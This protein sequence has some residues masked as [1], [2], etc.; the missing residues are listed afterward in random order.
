MPSA[1]PVS[2]MAPPRTDLHTLPTWTEDGDLWVVIET[3]KGTPNKLAFDP[4]LGAFRLTKVLPAGM[5]FPF[6]F[7]FIPGTIGEDGD[8]LD[9]LV[10]LDA[11]LWP[12][13]VVA[14]RLLGAFEA[15]QRED[16][17]WVRN[18][19]LVA[20][21]RKTPTNDGLKGIEDLDPVLLDEIEAFFVDYNRVEGRRF[22][23]LGRIG[24]KHARQMVEGAART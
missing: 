1:D 11:P 18:D 6:D 20:T 19:R 3:P 8:P 10:L 5:V 17:A 22:R 14:A 21:A 7:G 12:G 4:E 2:T 13:C 9:V 24:P 23:C 16:G 15:E